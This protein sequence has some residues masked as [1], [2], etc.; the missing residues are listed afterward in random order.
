MGMR[1][2]ENRYGKKCSINILK[3]LFKK[4]GFKPSYKC[5][6]SHQCII[7]KYFTP[8]TI[9]RNVSSLKRVIN[10]VMHVSVF[11]FAPLVFVK[12][13]N[14]KYA[15]MMIIMIRVDSAKANLKNES[16]QK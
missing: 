3:A 12:G 14:D 9:K 2:M 11:F 4:S 8:F 13:I 15:Y 6:E 1:Y 5:N 7:I 10:M 16:K